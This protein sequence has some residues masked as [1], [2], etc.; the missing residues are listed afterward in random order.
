MKRR[1]TSR[2]DARKKVQNVNA[3]SKVRDVFVPRETSSSSSS[4]SESPPSSLSSD[5]DQ[6]ELSES[7]E[8]SESLDG[9]TKAFTEQLTQTIIAAAQNPGCN[10]ELLNKIGLGFAQTGGS[11][12]DEEELLENIRSLS[13]YVK[14][15]PDITMGDPEPPALAEEPIPDAGIL[16]ESPNNTSTNHV[17]NLRSNMNQ[18]KGASL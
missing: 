5:S 13:L 11:Y 17:D 15:T 6:I 12:Q 10:S 1:N 3:V 4:E 8:S 7:S 2:D 14:P 9:E 18:S 16:G